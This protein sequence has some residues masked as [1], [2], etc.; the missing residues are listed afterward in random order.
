MK[1]ELRGRQVF[2]ALGILLHGFEQAAERDGDSLL[3]AATVDGSLYAT[4]SNPANQG[5]AD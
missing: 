1:A 2:E 5:T 3:R 4:A